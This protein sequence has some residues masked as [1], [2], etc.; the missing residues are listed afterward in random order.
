[1]GSLNRVREIVTARFGRLTCGV[2]KV[3]EPPFR[4]YH[5]R[6]NVDNSASALELVRIR[7]VNDVYQ[8][9]YSHPYRQSLWSSCLSV[10]H[11]L[12]SLAS[13]A[14]PPRYVFFAR[15]MTLLRLLTVRDPSNTDDLQ[16]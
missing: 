14:L 16:Q 12:P 2:A 1:M 11:M 3:Q 6:Y 4:I 10:R 13:R 5:L 15:A 9:T 7:D 8:A